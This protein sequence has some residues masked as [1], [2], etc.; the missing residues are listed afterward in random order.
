[1]TKENHAHLAYAAGYL[2]AQSEMQDELN[3]QARLVGMATERE[4]RLNTLLRQALNAMMD[5]DYDKRI[6]AIA[7][8]KEELE[9]TE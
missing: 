6:A 8:I 9:K 1:M 2:K 5:F 3:E 4:M 7:A